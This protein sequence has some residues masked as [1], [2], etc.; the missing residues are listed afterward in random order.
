MFRVLSLSA[1]T[2]TL[3]FLPARLAHAEPWPAPDPIDARGCL[4]QVFWDIDYG[5]QAMTITEDT[6][7][8]GPRW[9]DQVSSVKVIAGV[10][11]FYWDAR[12]SGESFRTGP[13]S[14]RYVGDHW[15]DQLSSMRCERPT[16][17]G[18]RGDRWR[19]HG[20]DDYGDDHK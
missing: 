4:V 2:L 11:D 20:G 1:I 17:Y 16:R 19:D 5:G 13:G 9:N 10:W 8:I 14:Y 12:Y 3:A 15:N 7:W 18:E 6:P